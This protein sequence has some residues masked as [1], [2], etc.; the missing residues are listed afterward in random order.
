MKMKEQTIL[1][2]G[3][4]LLA[5][6]ISMQRYRRR[7]LQAKTGVQEQNQSLSFYFP[8]TEVG[9]RFGRTHGHWNGLEFHESCSYL[10]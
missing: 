9:P 10:F 1:A 5:G 3:E 2:S 7:S 8:G 6:G 4:G